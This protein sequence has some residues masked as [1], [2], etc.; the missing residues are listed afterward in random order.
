[1]KIRGGEKGQPGRKVSSSAPARLLPAAPRPRP[2]P[3]SAVASAQ[4]S[5]QG[6][7]DP[8]TASATAPDPQDRSQAAVHSHPGCRRHMSA[9]EFWFDVAGLLL[10]HNAAEDACEAQGSHL[11][12]PLGLTLGPEVSVWGHLR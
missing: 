8:I 12:S 10:F 3:Q 7:T 9:R 6:Q 2:P 1:M 11:S 4:V 5:M